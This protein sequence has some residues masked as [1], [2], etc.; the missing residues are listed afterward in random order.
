MILLLPV[1]A[2]VTREGVAAAVGI[3]YDHRTCCNGERNRII[4]SR[5]RNR[6]W[7]VISGI[8]ICWFEDRGGSFHLPDDGVDL[9]RQ[10]IVSG[11]C[12]SESRQKI[13]L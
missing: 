12:R 6:E 4:Y 11:D 8:I 7:N 5:P 3:C 9:C 13:H 2:V 10:S 1:L